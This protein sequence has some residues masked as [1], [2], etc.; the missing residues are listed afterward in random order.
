MTSQRNSQEE[1]A[2]AESEAKRKPEKDG[3]ATGTR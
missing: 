2:T 1:A 3:D